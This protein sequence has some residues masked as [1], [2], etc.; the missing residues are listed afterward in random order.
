MARHSHWHN[1]Q[2]TKGKADA[3]KAKVF[4]KY[5]NAIAL[6]AKEAG[7]DAGTNFRL[8]IA[9]DAARAVNMPK[10]NIE[11]AIERGTG[12]G[13][14]GA[15]EEVVYELIGP[16]GVGLLV[17]AVTDNRARTVAEVKMIA[18][19]HGANVAG[20]GA[21]KWMFERKAVVRA[22]NVPQD[23]EPFELALID[24]GADDI[25]VDENGMTIVGDVT[26]LQKLK[27]AAEKGGCEI[28]SAGLEYVAKNTT[29][30]S[31]EAEVPLEELISLL[32]EN[33]DVVNVYTNEA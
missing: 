30:L 10:V 22:T 27:E 19:K 29:E 6:A 20:T 9:I 25:Q 2:L 28:A 11:R 3:A 26:V 21:V 8:R 17:E 7:G 32:D 23:R 16:G 12:T 4:T 33:D 15:M 14:G 5:A 13:E 24:A 1:I 31:K 18:N